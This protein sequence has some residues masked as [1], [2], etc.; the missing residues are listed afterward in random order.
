ML[1]LNAV[2]TEPVPLNEVSRTPAAVNL[3]VTNFPSAVPAAKKPPPGTDVKAVRLLDAPIDRFVRATEA[4]LVPSVKSAAA[5]SEEE[6]GFVCPTA[7]IFPA[8]STASALASSAAPPDP[9]NGVVVAMPADPKVG[10][11][12]PEDV[13]RERRHGQRNRIPFG[14]Q[15]GFYRSNQT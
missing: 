5:C 14:R 9:V 7:K 3:A 12:T 10:S 6:S 13:Y 1:L 8:L 4:P 11:N 15:R 2:S